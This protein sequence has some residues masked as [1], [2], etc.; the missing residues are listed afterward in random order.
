MIVSIHITDISQKAQFRRE[1]QA[2]I[3]TGQFVY[4]DPTEGLEDGAYCPWSELTPDQQ[5]EFHSIGSKLTK[6]HEQ[7]RTLFMDVPNGPESG[8]SGTNNSTR[9]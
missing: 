7:L 5:A 4:I 2:E 1:V 3:S 8:F 6:A 9:T